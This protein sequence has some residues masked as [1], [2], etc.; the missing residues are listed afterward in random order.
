MRIEEDGDAVFQFCE[1]VKDESGKFNPIFDTGRL[2]TLEVDHVLLATGQGTDLAILEGSAV[3]NTRGFV[4]ADPKTKMTTVPGVFAGGDAQHGPRTV[5]EAIRS[6]KIAAASIDAWLRG[7]PPDAG[8]GK[9]VRRA[10]VAPLPIVALDRTRRGRAAMPEKSVEEVLGEGN[11]VRI[12]Q[13]LTDAMAQAEVRRC[14]RCDICIGCGLCMATCSEMGID[15]LRM[16]ETPA[17]RLAYFDFTRPA[18]AVHRLRRL[19]PGL[20]DR[21]DPPRGR[22]R[23][24]AHDHHR[25]RRA[26][27]AT[28]ELQRLRCADADAGASRF[29]AR[30]PATAS[31]GAAGPRV[32]SVVRASASGP[33][34][35]AFAVDLARG[36]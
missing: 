24:A 1:S 11:Y 6:G 2:L 9:P 16:A 29:R 19:H 25:H 10:E 31:G 17:G 15:A 28:A 36:M 27:A 3:E 18:R 34:R 32:V 23:D 8:I 5:V 22:G 7:V 20:P 13:G 12:E 26:R 33:S 14:L 21:R 35:S 30:A 4:V